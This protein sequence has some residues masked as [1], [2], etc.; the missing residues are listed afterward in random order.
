MSR[1][2]FLH[3]LAPL[4]GQSISNYTIGDDTAFDITCK[5]SYCCY[6]QRI[7]HFQYT[8][9]LLLLQIS[10][11]QQY[12]PRH[13]KSAQKM[14][15]KIWR[16]T[17]YARQI[18]FTA[19]MGFS[20]SNLQTILP[21]EK[22]RTLPLVKLFHARR[23]LTNKSALSA[24]HKAA[25]EERVVEL[26][27]KTAVMPDRLILFRLID[28]LEGIGYTK[29][30][31]NELIKSIMSYEEGHMIPLDESIRW[32][33]YYGI[34]IGLLSK[35]VLMDGSIKDEKI[36]N[37]ANKAIN[38]M[39]RKLYAFCTTEYGVLG[40]RAFGKVLLGLYDLSMVRNDPTI[41]ILIA[42]ILEIIAAK[43]DP[44]LV[45]DQYFLFLVGAQKL[46]RTT[47]SG[48][49]K[50][51]CSQ[52][53]DILLLY[54]FKNFHRAPVN[55]KIRI[56]YYAS[57]ERSMACKIPGPLYEITLKYLFNRNFAELDKKDLVLLGILL[58][59]N[60]IMR[61]YVMYSTRNVNYVKSYMKYIE[62]ADIDPAD[63]I[64]I[65]KRYAITVIQ[66]NIH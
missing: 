37:L 11:S 53:C 26:L 15:I 63:R 7:Y 14:L 47:T 44:E 50:S 18:R 31:M 40:M 60:Y 33:Y 23:G 46:Y 24:G 59:S 19:T 30:L 51:L 54:C 62:N 61:N 48:Q 22:I 12:V 42:T 64:M 16:A 4:S 9:K 2:M 20:Q 55:K 27:K 8:G 57:H 25:F 58:T 36:S 28:E 5:G 1:Y 34:C 41:N 17:S 35:N 56:I 6:K 3:S 43:F 66:C 52:V 49:L 65:K 39:L 32:C 45:S 10:Q 29:E 38:E 21:I 13:T